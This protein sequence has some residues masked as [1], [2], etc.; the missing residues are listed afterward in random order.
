MKLAIMQPYFFPYIGYFQLMN[1]VDK[2]VVY[3]NI[4]YSRKGWINRNRLLVN[5][6][7]AYFTIPLL[8]DSD[9]LDVNERY[10]AESWPND[11]KKLLNRLIESYRKSPNFKEVYPLIEACLMIE[12]RNLFRFLYNSLVLTREYLAIKTPL[13]VSSEI[14]IDHKLRASNKVVAIC[15]ALDAE[16]YVNPIGGVEL[17]DKQAFSNHNIELKFLRSANIS[18]DQFSHPHVPFLSIIDIMMFNAKE[19][20]Q[21][22]LLS[23]S[24]E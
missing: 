15:K 2:F 16:T 13:I 19:S 11:R 14:P 22:L 18:Y 21:S 6:K 24:L 23:F 5:G 4:G 8:K 9:Y 1:N 12:E 20:L 3:D 17:Y 7:D 10:L